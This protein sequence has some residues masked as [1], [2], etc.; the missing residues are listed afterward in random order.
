MSSISRYSGLTDEQLDRVHEICD[1]FEEAIRNEVPVSIESQLAV[2][3]SEIRDSLLRELLE[4]ELENRLALNERPSS[5]E[6]IDRFPGHE[7]AIHR[8]FETS[9]DV[10]KEELPSEIGR[11][12]IESLLGSGGFANVYLANDDQLKRRVAIKVPHQRLVAGREDAG[13]YLNEAQVVAGLDHSHIVPVHDVGRTDEYPCYVISKYI[14]GLNLAQLLLSQKQLKPPA[15]A[16][17]VAD[18]ADALHYAHTHGLVHRD[19]KPS[20]ILLDENRKPYLADFGLAQ[21]DVDSTSQFHHAGT[22]AYMSP[23]QSR[24]EGHRVDG[25]SDIYSLGAVFY[26]ILTGRRTFPGKSSLQILQEITA[27]DPRPPRQIDDSIPRELERICMKALA[28]RASERYTTGLDM[29]DDL[30]HFLRTEDSPLIPSTTSQ[31]AIV[32][33]TA[34]PPESSVEPTPNSSQINALSIVP[35]GLRAFS[36]RD[37]DF[38]PHLLPGPHN[39]N[40]LPESICF[41]MT[42]IEERDPKKTFPIGLIYGPSG[43]GKSSFMKAGLMPRLS[44]NV[45]VIFVEATANETQTRLLNE[46]S[47]LFPSLP[48]ENDL[49]QALSAI[50]RGKLLAPCKKILIVVDQFEQW[51]HAERNE[52]NSELVQA[53]RQCDGSRLQCIAL[54]RDD[55]W[56]AVSRF[57]HDLEVDLVTGNNLL[58]VDLFGRDHA[59]KVLKAYGRAYGSLPE[60]PIQLSDEHRQFINDSID[61]LV[62]DGKVTCIRLALFAQMMKDKPWAPETLQQSGGVQ[63]LGVLF[64]EENFTRETANP[65]YRSHQSAV[66]NVLKSLLPDSGVVIKGQ[67][68]SYAELREVSGYAGRPKKF[69]ELIRIL[70]NELRLI[71]PTENGEENSVSEPNRFETDDATGRYYQLTHDYLVHSVRDWLTQQQKQ[72]PR[73]RAELRLAELTALWSRTQDQRYLPTVGEWVSIN[74]LTNHQT[75]TAEQHQMMKRAN[76]FYGIRL[77]IGIVAVFL[78]GLAMQ[79]LIAASRHRNMVARIETAME[80]LVNSRGVIVPYAI[81]DLRAYPKKLVIAELQSRIAGGDQTQKLALAYGQ[82]EYESPDIEFLVAQIEKMPSSEIPN[83]LTALSHSRT[84]GLRFIQKAF[85][86]NQLSGNQ[87]DFNERLAI[88]SLC[89][90]DASLAF[91]LCQLGS[92]PTRRTNFIDRISRWRGDDLDLVIVA[93]DITDPDLRSGICLGVGSTPEGQLSDDAK[94]AWQKVFSEWYLND[95]NTG[96]HSAAGWGL[97]KWN[98]NLPEVAPTRDPVGKQDWFVNHAGMTMMKLPAGRF[99]RREPQAFDHKKADSIPQTVE[100][101]REFFVCDREVSVGLF[102]Q[103]LNDT[104]YPEKERLR[105][106][107]RRLA[108]NSDFSPTPK[109]PVQRADWNDAVMFCNW[110][111][112]KEGRKPCYQRT[113]EFWDFPTDGRREKWEFIGDA[114]GY[115]LPT[116]AEWEYACRAGTVTKYSF[117][118]DLRLASNYCVFASDQSEVCGGKLPNGWGLFNLH[119]NITE[120]CQDWSHRYGD[121]KTV[122]DPSGSV[123]H[124]MLYRITRG[125]SFKAIPVQIAS[126]DRTRAA[127]STRSFSLGFRVVR[128]H[129]P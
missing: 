31:S 11:Y 76:R 16:S 62:V 111:S 10:S 117:G 12:K 42:R 46:L 67:M 105:L 88:T 114:G 20:N 95:P 49:K 102:R 69:D 66:R 84:A 18:I 58:M 98:F 40:G 81:K 93:L 61:E 23:E 43:C 85:A 94:Q 118:N 53:L 19:V 97:R 121:A 115:R 126:G 91:E 75:R 123:R 108:E 96:V 41:W 6:Y 8:A 80:T 39:R 48:E 44:E 52:Q 30:R 50:R 127:L 24:G 5:S 124:R 110:L 113:G 107:L 38:Y 109:H 87:W 7:P 34:L 29:A 13:R 63:G 25:R 129:E 89:L 45:C 99:V 92:D 68:R 9:G 2:A 27:G 64:L 15:A 106:D 17:I 119:G 104:D 78:A 86:E 125:G 112:Y 73:G 22:P 54:V 56:L 100:L 77:G 21:N 35:R 101:T 60:D 26:E 59:C 122:V 116:E 70:D 37:S 55:F 4:I 72:T 33:R 82:A 83:M 57:I 36:E 79:Q 74:A 1:Q 120:W 51:L 28:R 3:S 65:V 14:E 47:N 90:G 128:T 103:F 71:S 32:D